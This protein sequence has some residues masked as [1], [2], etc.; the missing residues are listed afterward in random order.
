M[1]VLGR[2]IAPFG[3]QGW[4]KIKP[5]GDEPETW[6][7]MPTWWLA[8]NA[9]APDH[10]WQLRTL[11]GFRIRD[12]EIAVS[13]SDVTDRTAAENLRGFYVAAPREALPPTGADEYYWADLIGLQVH[14]KEGQSLGTVTDLISTGVHDVLKVRSA[15]GESAEE[16]LIPFVA[17][18][19]TAVDLVGK[20]IKTDWDRDW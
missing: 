8:E 6:R 2:I 14:D 5:F 18:Y 19:I 10:C 9:D 13:F 3:V 7:K 1:I 16:R 12:K 11:T 15:A 20:I 4:M 17:A